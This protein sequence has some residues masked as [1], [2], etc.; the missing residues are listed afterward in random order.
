MN[1][2]WRVVSSLEWAHYS[3]HSMP[4]RPTCQMAGAEKEK[5]ERRIMF[6]NLIR[7]C[8]DVREEYRQVRAVRRVQCIWNGVV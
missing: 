2:E 3:Q 1:S 4:L 8:E 6:D 7:T 5:V